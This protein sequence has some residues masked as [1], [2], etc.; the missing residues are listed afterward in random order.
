MATE[1][2]M[3]DREGNR[4]TEDHEGVTY[5]AI[6]RRE[7]GEIISHKVTGKGPVR[8]NLKEWPKRAVDH[9]MKAWNVAG[10]HN[11]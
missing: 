7:H 6:Y 9:L 3:Y 10:I 11:W 1:T 2:L 8:C 5:F 4:V